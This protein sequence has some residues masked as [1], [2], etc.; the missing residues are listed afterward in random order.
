VQTN[1]SVQT[2]QTSIWTIGSTSMAG[3]G[4]V[5]GGICKSVIK[6]FK[7]ERLIVNYLI[8]PYLLDV[9]LVAHIEVGT[10]CKHVIC[11]L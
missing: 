9:D 5:G 11:S 2:M 4:R 6:Q 8:T 7:D 1:L 10:V 3:A